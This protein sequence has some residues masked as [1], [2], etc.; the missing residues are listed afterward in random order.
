ME[1]LQNRLQQVHDLI[2]VLERSRDMLVS[3]ATEDT[4]FTLRECNMELNIVLERLRGFEMMVPVFEKREP[5]SGAG[6]EVA[7]VLPYNGSAWLNTTIVSVYLVGNR[8]RVKFASRDSKI[9]RFTESLYKPIFGDDIHFDYSEGKTFIEKAISDPAIPAICLFGSDRHAL[10][11]E[12]AIKSRKKKFVFEG[13]GKDPFI[14][15]SGAN[16]KEAA[17]E[18]AFSKYIYAGQTCTAPERVYLEESIHDEF[19]DIFLE[20][21]RSVKVGDPRDPETEMGP[22]ASDLAIEN[23]KRQLDDAIKRG[24]KILLGGKIEGNYV[25]PTIVV[26]STEEMLGMQEETFG[27][28]VFIQAFDNVDMALSLTRNNRYGLRATVYGPEEKAS[29]VAEELV[30]EEYCHPVEKMTFG[31]FGTVAV[32]QTRAE[33]WKGA[34]VWKPVGG[35]GYSGWIWETVG[36]NFILKQGPKLLSLETSTGEFS[37]E[38]LPYA[39]H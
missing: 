29:S 17:R 16:I 8:V 32:N 28:V 10:P 35:Y 36:E 13:P 1:T 25:Y 33:S 30:G 19:V 22:V 18:L 31:R 4:S 37:V 39:G 12:E 24:G 21:S 23:I 3:Y 7:L 14:V 38:E 15:F 6:E 27:P 5:I 9:A 20:L 26:N 11:Y 34:L 2:E